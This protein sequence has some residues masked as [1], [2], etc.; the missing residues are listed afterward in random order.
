MSDDIY[1]I[2]VWIQLLF[3]LLITSALCRLFSMAVV[4]FLTGMPFSRKFERTVNVVFITTVT[5]STLLAVAILGLMLFLAVAFNA[6]GMGLFVF[7]A[8]FRYTALKLTMITGL[9]LTSFPLLASLL[10]LLLAIVSSWRSRQSL[11]K[12]D[13]AG[14]F[15]MIAFLIPV[16]FSTG[17][18][19]LLLT[20]SIELIL[21][22]FSLPDTSFL[23]YPM[24]YITP[25]LGMPDWY[26]F[27]IQLDLV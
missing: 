3:L 25:P 19:T 26:L 16:G 17:L 7:S 11:D 4:E 20:S 10:T 14:L 5:F 27:G 15:K 2:I 1:M 21:I 18:G 23:F 6:K 24:T 12:E 8:R 13:R 22:F 9:Y